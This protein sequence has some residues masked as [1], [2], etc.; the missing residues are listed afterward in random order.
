MVPVTLLNRPFDFQYWKK[1]PLYSGMDLSFDIDG[2]TKIEL[3]PLFPDTSSRVKR[4]RLAR[5]SRV[6]ETTNWNAIGAARH[7][8]RLR[9][10][11]HHLDY[12]KRY[13]VLP[14]A[15]IDSV[16]W[17]SLTHLFLGE[18]TITDL[19]PFISQ[20]HNLQM[21]DLSFSKI[22]RLPEGI[23][24]MRNLKHLRLT[25][26]SIKSLPDSFGGLESLEHLFLSSTNITSLPDYIGNLVNLKTLSL[27]STKVTGLPDWIGNLVNLRELNVMRTKVDR[28]PNTVGS[29]VNLKD[30]HL[31]QTK[32]STIPSSLGNLEN[33]ERLILFHTSVTGFPDTIGNLIGLRKILLMDTRA[34]KSIPPSFWGLNLVYL[35]LEGSAIDFLPDDIA[36]VTSLE[37]L[38]LSR[39]KISSMPRSIGAM[40]NLRE[41]LLG[42]THNLLELPEDIGDLDSLKHLDVQFSGITSLPD[43]IK[44]LRGPWII[45]IVGAD[46]FEDGQH[47][48]IVGEFLIDLVKGSPSLMDIVDQEEP[49][50]DD[51]LD[52]DPRLFRGIPYHWRKHIVD[53]YR[54]YEGWHCDLCYVVEFAEMFEKVYYH[55]GCNRVRSRNS[56]QTP[57]LW[58]LALQSAK[59]AGNCAVDEIEASHEP[60]FVRPIDPIY[61]LIRHQGSFYDICIHRNARSG[62][63]QSQN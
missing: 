43:S 58:P 29:L 28:L 41:L 46:V 3:I 53:G 37:T 54:M 7:G 30:L 13:S 17:T 56:I 23:G 52:S 22:L 57:A 40:K 5:N 61:Q 60:T 10:Y 27:C 32:I 47:P 39:L 49:V 14:P 51:V 63:S 20:L 38:D 8:D 50:D 6:I 42:H 18:S 11:V 15:I 48:G 55:L 16:D 9:V 26:T 19:P 44:T 24:E 33:L 2:V 59:L 4:R 45:S 62:A 21:I 36:N 1:T 12:F 31:G 25:K 35:N 34:L